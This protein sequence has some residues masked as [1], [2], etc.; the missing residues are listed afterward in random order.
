ME[1]LDTSRTLE[2]ESSPWKMVGLATLGAIMTL[3]PLAFALHWVE[4]KTPLEPGT[5]TAGFAAAGF[6]ALCTL[7]IAWRLFTV[8]GPVVTIGP[9]GIRD[10]RVTSESIPWDAIAGIGTWTHQGQRILVL[11]VTPEAEKKLLVAKLARLARLA[12]KAVGADG[13]CITATGLK[14][15][16]DRLYECAIAYANAARTRV[17]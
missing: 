17:E 8:S 15:S 11:Q 2:V 5:E 7:V 4:P 6:F 16:Y 1:T 12:N 10:T 14:I 3:I 9:Q 13:L